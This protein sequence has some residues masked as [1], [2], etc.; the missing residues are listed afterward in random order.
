MLFV[1]ETADVVLNHLHGSGEEAGEQ[2]VVLVL[3]Q[4]NFFFNQL[5]NK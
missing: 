2:V 5:R 3:V 4:Q 1:E